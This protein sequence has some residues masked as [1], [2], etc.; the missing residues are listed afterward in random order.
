MHIFRLAA[1]LALALAAAWPVA[2][3][4]LNNPGDYLH[5]IARGN[6]P[7]AQEYSGYGEV[8]TG[9]TENNI[10]V[11]IAD[12][13]Q[14][15][16][17]PAGYQPTIVSSSVEDDPVK[18]EEAG[19]GTGIHSVEVHYIDTAGAEQEEEIALNGT[20]AVT[21]EADD[22]QFI[23]RM[24]ALDV[25]T[26]LVAAGNIDAKN[27][28]AVTARIGVAGNFALSSMRMVPTGFSLYINGWHA[29]AVSA[30]GGKSATM[31]LRASYHEDE[32]TAGTYLFKDT[33]IVKET[34]SGWIPISP[35]LH[36]PAG[37]TIKISTWTT[38]AMS[39]S[40]SWRG[41]LERQ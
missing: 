3:R 29:S 37:A 13:T 30:G 35:P 32:V 24:Y 25:G 16:P 9:G 19:V 6:I 8:A 12:N 26:G 10:D 17:V 7:G 18:A 31:R 4:P 22:V 40:G 5:D 28:T 38:G 11:W 34:S 36:V 23:N 20:A 1:L 41:W 27:A 33:V 2:A 15:E 21:M 14:P 39:V